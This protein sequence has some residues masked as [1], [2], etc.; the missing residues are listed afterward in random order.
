MVIGDVVLAEGYCV[1]EA[2]EMNQNLYFCNFWICSTLLP[3]EICF[4]IYTVNFFFAMIWIAGW[5]FYKPLKPCIRLPMIPMH[6]KSPLVALCAIS[7]T[8]RHDIAWLA[9]T[10]VLKVSRGFVGN[11][12][13][14]KP[15]GEGTPWAFNCDDATLLSWIWASSNNFNHASFS[16][17]LR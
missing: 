7:V 8:K 11:Y 4:V 3:D 1:H 6:N 16:S 12:L 15:I 13:A 10:M 14:V 5:L 2:S 17:R 9:D